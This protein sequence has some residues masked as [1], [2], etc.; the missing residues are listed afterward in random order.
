[1]QVSLDDGADLWI[2]ARRLSVAHLDDGLAAM[3]HLNDAGHD[4]VRPQFQRPNRLELVSGQP[5]TGAVALRRDLPG[6][7]P[8]R[9]MGSRREALIFGS[10]EHPYGGKTIRLASKDEPRR[11]QSEAGPKLPARVRYRQ[12]ISVLKGASLMTAKGASQ[13]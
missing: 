8:Q 5:I 6:R 13:L 1:P 9:I 12:G 10:W 3:G 4:A 2:A 11:H 7:G